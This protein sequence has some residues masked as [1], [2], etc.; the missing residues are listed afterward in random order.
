MADEDSGR[1]PKRDPDVP[2]TAGQKAWGLSRELLI[3]VVGALIVS[4]LLRA[5]VGQMF[6]IPSGSMEN[7]LMVNDR[8]VVQKITDF[9]RGQ[10]VVFADPGQ[11]LTDPP[12][13]RSTARKVFEFIGVL[14]N[15]GQEYLIKRV[16]GIPGDTVICC[17]PTGRITVNGYPLD[18]TSYL[19]SDPDGGQVAPSDIQFKVVVP[20]GRI[21]VMGDHR[22]NSAD[23][24]CHLDDQRAGLPNGMNAFVPITKVVGPAIAISAPLSRFGALRKPAT[25]D[26]VPAPTAPAPAKPTIEP[27]GVHC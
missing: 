11:W 17:D 1:R 22:N 2:R 8:V 26:G 13:P 5:F 12:A 24:R 23:S 7:T 10:V 21:F 18:E 15:S 6:T 27:A 3:V 20:A 25:F 4:S 19:Y 16:V 14:P 9:Q